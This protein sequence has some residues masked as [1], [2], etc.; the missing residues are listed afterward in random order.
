VTALLI[1]GIVVSVLFCATAL[2]IAVRVSQIASRAFLLVDTIHSRDVGTQKDLLDRLMT[3]RWEDLI[4]LRSVEEPEIGGFFSPD[5]QDEPTVKVEAGMWGHLSA[6]RE[7][8]SNEEQA[9]LD[10]DFPAE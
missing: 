7:R 10:E 5:E 4:A 6:L 8:M 1:M 2:A 9:M 3:V